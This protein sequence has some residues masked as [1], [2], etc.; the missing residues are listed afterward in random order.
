M[1]RSNRASSAFATSLEGPM[2]AAP[3]PPAHMSLLS[4]R[5]S[6]WVTRVDKAL[7][8]ALLLVLACNPFEAGYP[9]LGHFLFATYTNLELVLFI[10]A[11]L[12]LLKLLVDPEARR[13]FVRM[14]LLLPVL[15]LFVSAVVSTLFAEYRAQGTHFTYR[16]LM[17]AMIMWAAWEALRTTR[18]LLAALVIL[19]GAG[20][21][22]ATLGLLEYAT[23]FNIEPLLR[24]FK[25]MPTTVGGAL[26]LSGSFEYANGAA[27]YFEMLLPIVLGL[28]LLF[29]SRRLLGSLPQLGFT[30]GRRKAIYV[31][32]LVAA[33]IFMM[34]LLLTFSRAALAGVGVALVSFAIFA[35]LR[36]LKSMS[37]STGLN[38]SPLV[39]R[40]LLFGLLAMI[41]SAGY[42]FI[43]Q[44]VFR[45]RLTTE[46]DRVWYNVSYQP[47]AVPA[48]SA[49]DWVTVPLTVR[50]EGPMLWRSEGALSVHVSYH[51]MSADKS[52]Y[53]VFEGARTALPGNIEPGQSAT[54]AALVQAP[55]Q[56]GNYYLQ[57]DMVQENVTWF[58]YK[59]GTAAS[60]AAYTVKP[61]S[62]SAQHSRPGG[63]P[64][65]LVDVQ[66]STNADTSTVQRTKLWKAA[67]AMFRAHP[68]TGVGPDGFRN[69]YGRYA[70]VTD[71]NRNIYTNNTY[72]EFFTNLGLLGGLSF[73]WLAGAVLWLSV[74][75]LL[76]G[77]GD[78]RWALGMGVT[79]SLVAFFFHGFGDYFLF[80]T[81]LYTI[82]WLLIG[83]GVLWT[84]LPSGQPTDYRAAQDSNPMTTVTS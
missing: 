64:P 32:L 60:L 38:I 21:L 28:A 39:A 84:R 81:P 29:S 77:A 73:L 18:R 49:G 8:G 69:L 59:N 14:P 66:V 10:L 76:R 80:S 70:N 37:V 51:W 46:D 52:R 75:G 33:A 17:G 27:M 48:L 55:S 58:S 68:I 31:L 26:R 56:P 4:Q 43:T 53:L 34:A 61:S 24:A 47:G 71:W 65:P 22:S 20:L 16:L 41:L 82:F 7:F 72:I 57:W 25:P 35:F 5:V 79:A 40:S 54:V 44:P 19:V 74:R 9:P 11:G 45:L 50:N 13:R 62:T 23:W 2:G 6:A 42:I 30:E 3:A 83:I 63:A 78:A 67:F 15:G 36:R 1:T 12:W